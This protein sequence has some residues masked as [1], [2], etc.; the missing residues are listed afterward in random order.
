MFLKT[1]QTSV[2]VTAGIL[3]ND[4]VFL[5]C[6]SNQ[7]TLLSNMKGAKLSVFIIEGP[8]AQHVENNTISPI[9]LN[10]RAYYV[11]QNQHNL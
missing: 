10:L 7:C 1:G 8:P 4:K 5:F 9:I 3:H 2:C 6:L 11:S